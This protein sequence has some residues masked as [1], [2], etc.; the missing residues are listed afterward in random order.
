VPCLP[1]LTCV[2]LGSGGLGCR[3]CSVHTVHTITMM[4]SSVHSVHQCANPS[5]LMSLKKPSHHIVFGHKTTFA[6]TCRFG[7]SKSVIHKSRFCNSCEYSMLSP[8]C[9]I[10]DSICNQLFEFFLKRIRVI[11]DD[12]D[13][14]VLCPQTMKISFI[15]QDALSR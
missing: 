13:N 4:L 8:K 7:W 14:S 11:I 10:Q 1:V 12:G 3:L 15:Y 5:S 6:H 9:S 2:E